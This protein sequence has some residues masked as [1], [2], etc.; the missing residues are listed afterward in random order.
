[1]KVLE[2]T[3]FEKIV[4][5]G[6]HSTFWLFESTGA[7]GFEA[8]WPRLEAL[9]CNYEGAVEGPRQ[10]Y[11]VDVPETSNIHEVR[12]ILQEGESNGVW[13]VEEA[14]IGHK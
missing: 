4:G 14:H 2:D 6:G 10:L 12:A 5:R 1:V 7:H 3:S 9:S 8:Y 11:V 13:T